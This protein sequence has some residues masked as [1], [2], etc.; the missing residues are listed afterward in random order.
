M[1]T[2][3]ILIGL[4]LL[5]IILELLLGVATGFDLFII[6]IILIISGGVGIVTST[7]L[8]LL[9]VTALCFT[10]VLVGRNFVKNKLN[11]KS[12]P[13]NPDALIGKT[14]K[15][16][17]KITPNHPG[18]VKLEGEIWRAQSDQDIDIGQSVVVQSISGVTLSVI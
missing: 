11:F 17:K 9:S 14:A 16:V 5:S 7:T 4:G 6:G 3:Y 15:V 8:A 18:Q 1:N 10:Y 2:S 13:T 12:T